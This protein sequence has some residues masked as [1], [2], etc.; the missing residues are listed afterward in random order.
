MPEFLQ[1]LLGS[2]YAHPYL[3]V[4]VGLLFVGELVLLPA[5]YLS[6]AGR[7][8]LAYVIGIAIIATVLSDLVW[9]FAGR[10]FPASALRRLPGRGTSRLV[11]GLDRLFAR[12]G[13]QVVFLS[14][15]VYGT[16][17]AA[18][19]LAGVHDLPFRPYLVA[20]TLGVAAL[21]LTLSGIAWV[22]AGTAERYVD[23]VH[24]VKLAFVVFV[25]LAAIGYASA[26]RVA[27]QRWSQ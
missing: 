22:V 12:R 25:L 26:A 23:V 3:Y 16:R 27:R 20:N 19:I 9:Y 17:T 1:P 11:L 15:F 21:T 13:A 8:D 10:K 6:I 14:K 5:I 2:L 18:Q 24:S 7:L 4:F